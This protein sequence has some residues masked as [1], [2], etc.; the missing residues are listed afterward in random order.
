M[1]KTMI[2]KTKMNMVVFNIQNH[3]FILKQTHMS[4]SKAQKKSK[5]KCK[6][7]LKNII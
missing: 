3:V 5:K 6:R 7:E 1:K 2:V 4:Q